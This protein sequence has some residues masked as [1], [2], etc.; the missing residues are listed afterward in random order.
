MCGSNRSKRTSPLVSWGWQAYWVFFFFVVILAGLWPDNSPLNQ[1]SPHKTE[2][3]SP[4][5]NRGKQKAT[6]SE[7]SQARLSLAPIKAV[8]PE[9]KSFV[10]RQDDGRSQQ[11]KDNNKR[12]LAAQES[13]ALWAKIMGIAAIFTAFI[14]AFGLWLLKRTLEETKRAA[15][16]ADKMVIE[17]QKTTGEAA[18]SADAAIK[19]VVTTEEHS[20]KNLRAYVLVE[21]AA[22]IFRKS[23]PPKYEVFLKNYGSSPAKNVKWWF[24]SWM[25]YWP[26]RT[27][28]PEPPPDF[29]TAKAVL[30][31]SAKIMAQNQHGVALDNFSKWSL[32]SETGAIY[33]YGKCTYTDAF[34]RHRE[35]TYLLLYRGTTRPGT[36]LVRPDMCGNDYT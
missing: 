23:G 34:G 14:T 22:I 2:I 9:S 24:H 20:E 1:P 32:H 5:T 16:A 10:S 12:D 6:Q 15:F 31:P 33:I 30:G 8:P 29:Q 3:E 17:A 25:D 21:S 27:P 26:R 36:Y 28:L 18:R 7:P 4:H 35:S 11:E 13:M 19:S